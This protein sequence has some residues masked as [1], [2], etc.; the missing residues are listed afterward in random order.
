MTAMGMPA[1]GVISWGMIAVGM[2]FICARGLG[3]VRVGRV[4]LAGPMSRVFIRM[5]VA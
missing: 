1:E 5:G 4:F 3:T 2:P